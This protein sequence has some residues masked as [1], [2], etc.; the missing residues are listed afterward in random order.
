MGK[1]A[2][3]HSREDTQLERK[4][5]PQLP[6]FLLDSVST[7]LNEAISHLCVLSLFLLGCSIHPSLFPLFLWLALYLIHSCTTDNTAMRDCSPSSGSA[8]P[9]WGHSSAGSLTKTFPWFV[10]HHHVNWDISTNTILILALRKMRQ[11]D[12]K[13]KVIFSYMA[14]LCLKQQTIDTPPHTHTTH[15]YFLVQF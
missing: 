11:Q 6:W 4:L 14:S 2:G 3:S 10:P 1:G 12:Q 15:T 5:P 8:H 13:C 7:H 9:G